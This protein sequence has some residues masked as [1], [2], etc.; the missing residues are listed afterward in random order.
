[1]RRYLLVMMIIGMTHSVYGQIV[2]I[3]QKRL[4]ADSSGF[5]GSMYANLAINRTTV[6]LLNVNT[7]GHVSYNFGKSK[8]LTI[9]ELSLVK[10][11]GEKFSNDGFL[12]LRYTGSMSKYVSWETFTQMQ[13]NTLTKID[14][15]WL[16][17][18]GTRFQLTDYDNALF[19]FG[20]LYMYEREVL[21][22]PVETN[23][24]HRMS[25]YFSFS[26][27]PQE[28]ISFNSTTYIQPRL[29]FWT[30]Y[31]LLTENTLQLGITD[32]LSFMVRFRLTYDKFPPVDVPNLI[33]DMHNGLIYRFD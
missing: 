14:N 4:E 33:Y 30:D 28:T 26:M 19:F 2:N 29:D 7:G 1:M 10:G 18:T 24:D 12:H 32:Q 8:I 21:N 31:R 11:S 22:S 17:G 3:E 13:Y 5:R 15:R 16:T 23:N 9:A 25:A 6:N 20:I 27:K